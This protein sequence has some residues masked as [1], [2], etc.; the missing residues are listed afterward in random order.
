MDVELGQFAEILSY[1]SSGDNE[2]IMEATNF[3]DDKKKNCPVELLDFCYQIANTNIN[4]DN[5]PTIFQAF[6]VMNS[7]LHPSEDYMLSFIKSFWSNVDESFQEAILHLCFG[8]IKEDYQIM[9]NQA[10]YLILN[11]LALSP[12][13]C[14]YV[15]TTLDVLCDDDNKNVKSNIF[16]LVI[17]LCKTDIEF[18]TDLLNNFHIRAEMLASQVGSIDNNQRVLLFNL[19]DSIY[20]KDFEKYNTEEC[21]NKY[22]ALFNTL[23]QKLDVNECN[24]VIQT[25]FQ[26]VKNDFKRQYLHENPNFNLTSDFLKIAFTS[27]PYFL[28]LALDL[29]FKIC[30]FEKKCFE[31]QIDKENYEKI[32]DRYVGNSEYKSSLFE[33]YKFPGSVHPFYGYVSSFIKEM[34]IVENCISTITSIDDDQTGCVDFENTPD[35]EIPIEF[36]YAELLRLFCQ[37]DKDLMLQVYQ[38]YLSQEIDPSDWKQNLSKL[39]ILN[40]LTT[41]NGEDVIIMMNNYKGYVLNLLKETDID[42][43]QEVICLILS[44]INPHIIMKITQD[45]YLFF[46]DILSKLS[47]KNPILCSCSLQVFNNIIH[48]QKIRSVECQ[49]LNPDL[50]QIT[51]SYLNDIKQIGDAN[52]LQK[53][54]LSEAD[55]LVHCSKSCGFSLDS[56]IEE[57]VNRLYELIELVYFNP[58]QATPADTTE[59]SYLFGYFLVLAKDNSSIFYMLG[60]GFCIKIIEFIKRMDHLDEDFIALLMYMMQNILKH[61]K[62]NLYPMFNEILLACLNSQNSSIVKLAFQLMTRIYQ[63]FYIYEV[64]HISERLDQIANYFG[65]I[66]YKMDTYPILIHSLTSILS[67][68]SRFITSISLEDERNRKKDENKIAEYQKL[69]KEKIDIRSKLVSLIGSNN[70]NYCYMNNSFPEQFLEVYPFANKVFT[71]KKGFEFKRLPRFYNG[72][73]LIQAPEDDEKNT[74]QKTISLDQLRELFP[75][76]F[77]MNTEE[78][79]DFDDSVPTIKDYDKLRVLELPQE[80][81][82]LLSSIYSE[83]FSFDFSKNTPESLELSNQIFS[84]LFKHFTVAILF[85][86]KTTFLKDQ[87]RNFVNLIKKY[88][89]FGVFTK[90][91]LFNY[92][93][94]IYTIN[95]IMPIKKTP[96]FNKAFIITPIIYLVSVFQDVSRPEEATINQALCLLNNYFS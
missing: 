84:E 91:T 61:D 20:T 59:L 6:V 63:V 95:E 57:Q 43:I 66:K 74:N 92:Y 64:D 17:S 60:S 16:S 70:Y 34:N 12:S 26:M 28:N 65:D 45:D 5:F 85:F 49:V 19:F 67:N 78:A 51:L 58:L 22:F 69:L 55:L 79:V 21:R 40:S 11:L 42:I 15:L 35:D 7:L 83:F 48:S 32:L 94:F 62:E 8:T 41:I 46:I 3:C 73:K 89:N 24:E 90:E 82:E 39:L 29:L 53:A 52:L 1:I 18:D 31:S 4:S 9:P 76:A 50:L 37:L 44:S 30:K 10:C 77:D 68:N 80:T 72:P 2:K 47:K 81:V 13:F 27:G 54:Y 93:N 86:A 87:R 75:Y 88:V 33:K 36:K 56:I 96:A 38:N 25:I 71:Y 14:E 23:L